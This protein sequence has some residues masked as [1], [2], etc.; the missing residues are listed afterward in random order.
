MKYKHYNRTNTCDRCREENRITERSRLYSGNAIRWIDEKGNWTGKWL[1]ILCWHKE[2]NND[3]FIRGHRR[4]NNQDPN[5]TN[6]MGDMFQELSCRF[7]DAKDLNK[8]NDN[9][10]FQVDHLCK[11]L[12]YFQT[13]GALYNST[14]MNWKQDLRKLKDGFEVLVLYCASKDGKIIERIYI[15]PYEEILRLTGITI[16]KNSSRSS[17]WYE[18][19]RVKDKEILIRINNIWKKILE[20]YDRN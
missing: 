9:Y 19:H 5:S 1:C 17:A 12:G 4:T 15:I 10:N 8:E 3:R 11:E 7:Y 6:V 20:E 16:T 13:K 2:D 18:Q 14:Y